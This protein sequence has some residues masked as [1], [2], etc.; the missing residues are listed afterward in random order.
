M[1]AAAAGISAGGSLIGGLISSGGAQDAAATNAAAQHEAVQASLFEQQE[2]F[3]VAQ[4]YYGSAEANSQ[5]YLTGGAGAAQN[6]TQLAANML[7]P[8]AY[9]GQNFA[10]ELSNEIGTGQ[11]GQLGA[12]PS[13]TDF[14]QLP[15]YQFTLDQGMKAAQNAAASQGLGI[16]GAA[17]KG[18]IGYAENLANT[19]GSQYLQN[20]WANQN[21]RYNILAGMMGTGATASNQ[22]ASIY[23]GTG[24]NL[25]SGFTNTGNTL[26]ATAAGLGGASTSAA[27]SSGATQAQAIANTAQAIGNAQQAGGN[28]LAS[29]FSGAGSSLNNALTLQSLM[30]RGGGSTIGDEFAN[31]API[32]VEGG[33]FF[34]QPGT[35]A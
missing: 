16:S 17:Q 19:F 6:Y 32:P 8:F 31:S 15:G 23:Q 18:A 7:N 13:L 2:A 4:Q 10:Q 33:G 3:R 34:G 1:V 30:N 29:G 24:N 35:P 22:L 20:Y 14:S 11:P 5:A 9:M 12:Q 21:N 28:I 27:A 26:A 25:L